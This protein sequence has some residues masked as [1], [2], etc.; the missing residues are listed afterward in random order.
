[1]YC[2]KECF[3]DSD[4]RDVIQRNFIDEGN[5]DFCGELA[6]RISPASLSEKFEFLK[7]EMFE[8]S[9]VGNSLASCFQ[10]EFKVFNDLKVRNIDRLLEHILV[11]DADA[12]TSNFK[13][14][15]DNGKFSEEWNE[16][17][18]E[19][20]GKNRFFPNTQVFANL[21]RG[22]KSSELRVFEVILSQLSTTLPIDYPLYR[23]RIISKIE[24]FPSDLDKPPASVACDGRANPVGISYLYCSDDKATAVTEVRPSTGSIVHIAQLITKRSIKLLDLTCP[25]KKFSAFQFS[26]TDSK[27]ALELIVLLERLSEELSIP[28][29]ESRHLNYLPT[30]FFSEFIKSQDVFE[31]LVFSSSFT[32]KKNLVFFS[33]ESLDIV[34]FQRY[35]K[36]TV[37]R[38][39]H[40]FENT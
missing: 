37:T 34:H 9:E 14:I 5:C 19:L 39:Q 2:C 27:L 20:I 30:Q 3:W 23:A 35:E 38:T 32:N 22:V 25:R 28:I 8:K 11:D 10:K 29:A 40:E 36:V 21:F 31:G 16:L 13:P 33:E 26:D 1:M 24:H 17:R 6:P 4:L 18:S 12:S 15:S 7:D